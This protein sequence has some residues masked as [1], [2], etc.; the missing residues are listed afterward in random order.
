MNLTWAQF[1][2][3]INAGHKY[4]YETLDSNRYYIWTK[5]EGVDYVC[6]LFFTETSDK[7]DFDNNYKSGASDDSSYMSGP[8]DDDGKHYTRAESRPIGCTTWFTMSGDKIDSPQKIGGG[9]DIFWDFSN[10]DDIVSAPSGFKRKKIEFTFLDEVWIKE[11]SIYFHDAP[12]GCYLDFH[13]VCPAGSY[14]LKND[15]TPALASVDTI[16]ATYANR[17]RMSGDCAMGDELNTESA[18]N[19]IPAGM[20][21]WVAITTPEA[22]STSYGYVSIELYRERTVIL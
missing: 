12:K 5:S 18:S 4:F 3:F 10:S 16:I 22:D 6:I 19:K 8:V 2:D 14:Y 11:G 7:T 13:V 20:K 15:G 9:K 1:K 17:H 21:F